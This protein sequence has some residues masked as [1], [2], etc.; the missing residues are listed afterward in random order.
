M[1][2]KIN[3]HNN[4][5]FNNEHSCLEELTVS[6]VALTSD[7]NVSFGVSVP[8]QLNQNQNLKWNSWICL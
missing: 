8:D 6:S 7:R 3:N 4:K 2:S 1:E 5:I